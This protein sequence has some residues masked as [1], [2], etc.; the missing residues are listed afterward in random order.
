MDKNERRE[1]AF[2]IQMIATSALDTASHASHSSFR[3]AHYPDDDLSNDVTLLDKYLV[4]L[5]TAIKEYHEFIEGNE[6]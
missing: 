4:R 2:K 6:D 5:K 1:L 3:M